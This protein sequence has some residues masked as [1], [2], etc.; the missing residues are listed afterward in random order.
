MN[1]QNR[2]NRIIHS[3]KGVKLAD[4]GR[5]LTLLGLIVVIAGAAALAGFLLRSTGNWSGTGLPEKDETTIAEGISG[6]AL[7]R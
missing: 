4:H 2:K 3:D 7:V 6:A 5:I 1:I